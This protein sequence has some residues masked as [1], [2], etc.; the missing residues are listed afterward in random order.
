MSIVTAQ[1]V[2]IGISTPT[3]DRIARLQLDYQGQTYAL[4][5]VF[6]THKLDRTQIAPPQLQQALD[7]P[8]G[9]YL[10]VAETNYY[11]LWIRDRP[12]VARTFIAPEQAAPTRLALQ[13]ASIWL[14]QELWAQW[15]SLL[16]AKQLQLIADDL[17]AVTP[18]IQSRSDLD[19]LLKIDPLTEARLDKWTDSDFERFDC[20]LYQIAQ[21][22]IGR[23]FGTELTIEI[24]RSMPALLQTTLAAILKL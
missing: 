3:D 15:E 19:R 12:I 11:S 16:G 14:V 6:A 13:Q 24:V 4:A 9:S 7:A 20:Q 23:Q 17:I 22:K 10:V 1:L 18:P 2:K 21:H 8:A 5:R